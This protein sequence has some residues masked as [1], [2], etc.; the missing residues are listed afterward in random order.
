MGKIWA[1]MTFYRFFPSVYREANF[2]ETRDALHRQGVKIAVIEITTDT[3]DPMLKQDDVDLLIQ[4]KTN[5]VLWHKERS[6]NLLVRELPPECEYVAWLDS[7]CV[8]FDNDWP[9]KA[10]EQ[11]KDHCAV[12]LCSNIKFLKED[13]LVDFERGT[14]VHNLTLKHGQRKTASGRVEGSP[15][16]CWMMKR[17]ILQQIQLY[18]RTIIGGGDLLFAD[19]VSFNPIGRLMLANGDTASGYYQHFVDWRNKARFLLSQKKKAVALEGDSKHLYHDERKYRLYN[20]R[21]YILIAEHYDPLVDL[22]A[23]PSGLYTIVN[24]KIRNLLHVYFWLR[25]QPKTEEHD[26]LFSA[27]ETLLR[28]VKTFSEGK[29]LAKQNAI[30]EKQRRNPRRY[31]R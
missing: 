29:R 27:Y 14:Y 1:I 16:F 21:H 15:G 25:E 24:P 7:D 4:M 12:Q 22:Q 17:R 23:E 11:L 26:E 2:W 13:G 20:V 19:T 18:D 6:L 10:I 28:H 30:K 8:L 9:R 3:T 31:G 5:S